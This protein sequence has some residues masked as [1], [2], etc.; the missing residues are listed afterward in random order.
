MVIY[1]FDIRSDSMASGFGREHLVEL[2]VIP[3]LLRPVCIVK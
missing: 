1:G 2:V 3:R